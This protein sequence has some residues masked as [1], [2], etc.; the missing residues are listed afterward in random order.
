MLEARR[1]LVGDASTPS[2]GERRAAREL[3]NFV[4]FQ[5]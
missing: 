5:Y 4:E 3:I 2:V 1:A